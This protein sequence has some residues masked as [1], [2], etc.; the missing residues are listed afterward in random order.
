MDEDD[1]K[2]RIA[3]PLR[4]LEGQDLEPLSRAELEDRISRLHMEIR[5]SENALETKSDLKGAAELLFK[6]P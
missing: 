4:D 5:R 3:G 6:R 2:T 1:L